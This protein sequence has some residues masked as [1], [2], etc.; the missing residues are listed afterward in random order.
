MSGKS[1]EPVTDDRM[2][3]VLSSHSWEGSQSP[4]R[5]CPPGWQ[6]ALASRTASC[7]WQERSLNWPPGC[8]A[9]RASWKPG[10]MHRPLRLSE[11]AQRKPE[12]AMM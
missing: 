7:H 8:S 11:G 9:V 1:Q 4:P 2:V 3:L 12:G 5:T 6:R 10:C